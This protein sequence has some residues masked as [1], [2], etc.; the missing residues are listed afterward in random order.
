MTF[1]GAEGFTEAS[2]TVQLTA[3]TQ[4]TPLKQYATIAAVAARATQS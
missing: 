1:N 4:S 2:D 3:V